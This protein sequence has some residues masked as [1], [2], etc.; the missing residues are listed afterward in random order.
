MKVVIP[1]DFPSIIADDKALDLLREHA[2]VV[3]YNNRAPSKE[4][5]ISR[6]RDAQGAINI[7][8]YSKFTPAVFDACPKLKIISVLGI[9]TDNVDLEAAVRRG[10]LVCNTP[11]YS[12]VS[13][14]EHSL[15]LMLAAARQISRLDSE[16]RAGKW[17]RLP[18]I[19]LHGKTL[20]IIGFGDIAR[21]VAAIGR[22]IGMDVI[23]WTFHPSEERAAKYNVRFVEL[24]ELLSTSDV[25]SINI[26][27]SPRT[28]GL[29]G[30]RELKLMKPTAILVNTARAAIV[31]EAALVEAL[32]SGTIAAAGLDV[33]A[34]EPLPPDSPLLS[35]PNVVVT[36][37]TAGITPEATAAGNHM[38]VDNIIQ[39][40]KGKPINVRKPEA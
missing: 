10:I 19:Q 15:T 23:V 28:Q 20:G 27:S 6:L 37:H 4:E 39:Y 22:G 29:I 40:L 11:G 17:T 33:F 34:T 18:M 12:A 35:L 3:L 14:G 38:V 25:V 36:P 7:R 8:A 32:K 2:E 13:V 16:L 26:R 9:G 1:D 31:D 24:D 21:Q 30:A 5:F